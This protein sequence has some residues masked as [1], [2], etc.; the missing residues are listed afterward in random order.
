[1]KPDQT[2]VGVL[3]VLLIFFAIF[4]LIERVL[5]RGRNRVQP[6]WR[7]G[8]KTDVVYWF[9]TILAT[10]PLVRLMLIVPLS[11]LIISGV[12]SVDVLKLGTYDGF[13]PLSRQPGWLQAIQIYLLVD[14]ASYWIHRLFHRGRWWPF[15]AVHHSS[16]DLDWLASLRVHPVN[17]LI[18]KL[19]QVTPVLL[20]GYDPLVTLSTAPVLT[21]YSIFIH[22]NVNWD[23]GPFRS[24]LASP[25]F[26]RWHHSR[27]REAWDKNF[28]GLLPVWDIIFGTYYMPKGRYPENFGICEPMPDGYFRQMWAP[29][30]WLLKQ[31]KKVDPE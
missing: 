3:V 30:G 4:F 28:A 23:L 10:K 11:I 20:M 29:F 17:D 19:A 22:A 14:F 8:W 6:L 26:H 27:E 7:R 9:M 16:E 21:F 25:V 15:H 24:V 31:K 2:F 5:G 1:M 13:G 12:T 18:N